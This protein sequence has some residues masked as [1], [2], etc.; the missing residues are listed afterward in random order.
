MYS[1]HFN[2]PS[3][4]FPVNHFARTNFPRCIRAKQSGKYSYY[5]S[6]T[7]WM[8]TKLLRA[9]CQSRILSTQWEDE[10]GGAVRT[11][12]GGGDEYL[13]GSGAEPDLSPVRYPGQ[14]PTNPDLETARYKE[15]RS[16]RQLL[17][18]LSRE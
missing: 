3:Q 4:H 12:D 14:D 13:S 8:P 9:S 2:Y 1:R 15:D 10:G 6:I 11:G 17:E 16:V 5:P 18:E 7:G